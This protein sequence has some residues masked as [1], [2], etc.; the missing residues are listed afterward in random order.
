MFTRRSALHRPRRLMAMPF[1]PSRVTR[2]AIRKRKPAPNGRSSARMRETIVPIGMRGLTEQMFLV[3]GV[4]LRNW[5]TF[6]VNPFHP[7]RPGGALY[8]H[9]LTQSFALGK[10]T[11]DCQRFASEGLPL[12]IPEGGMSTL[13]ASVS[14]G[15]RR[16]C[17]PHSLT[18]SY[19][20]VRYAENKNAP[21][22]AGHLLQGLQRR[23]DSNPRNLSVQRFSR[24]PHSTAL[25]LLWMNK[26]PDRRHSGCKS[27]L[28][29]DLSKSTSAK[30][31]ANYRRHHFSMNYFD[32]RLILRGQASATPVGPRVQ[33][34]C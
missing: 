25:P 16:F 7:T 30:I 14:A 32:N 5:D 18:Q 3:H 15:R 20:L 23:R 13:A 22:E 6:G 33:D 24:P 1:P 2:N 21:P 29:A 26:P 19:A 12:V 10:E 31:V 34:L 28:L 27:R 17:F 8:L 11:N 4:V 9:S